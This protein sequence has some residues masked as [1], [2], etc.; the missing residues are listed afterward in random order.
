MSAGSSEPLAFEEIR[1]YLIDDSHV[2]D[3]IIR[4]FKEGAPKILTALA[5]GD[6]SQLQND[7]VDTFLE[8]LLYNDGRLYKRYTARG[9]EDTYYINIRGLGG[10]YFYEAPEFDTTGYF[11]SIDEA[12]Y[13]IE[14]DWI[15]LVSSRGRTFRKPFLRKNESKDKVF[16]ERGCPSK[17]R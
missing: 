1:R 16:L 7:D 10:V 17:R 8:E 6:D 13:A 5:V 2:R 12:S 15:D 11:L 4:T 3:Q 14:M 9:S